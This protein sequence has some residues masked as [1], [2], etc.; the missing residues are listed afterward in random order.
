[1]GNY[2]PILKLVE[3]FLRNKRSDQESR[4]SKENL[5]KKE[6]DIIKSE[7]SHPNRFCAAKANMLLRFFR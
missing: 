4:I 7:L 5:L 1:M 3:F 6:L 2:H